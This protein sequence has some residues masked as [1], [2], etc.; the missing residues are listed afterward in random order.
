MVSVIGPE[1]VILLFWGS[2]FS[3]LS[4]LLNRS[5]CEGIDISAVATGQ[6]RG[7]LLGN[8]TR[9]PAEAQVAR[10]SWLPQL[11][12]SEAGIVTRV[13]LTQLVLLT[14]ERVTQL[15]SRL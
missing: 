1:K 9:G 8:Y 14:R 11:R 13:C 2:T 15:S 6:C 4:M 7:S 10:K 12:R 5:E 3:S